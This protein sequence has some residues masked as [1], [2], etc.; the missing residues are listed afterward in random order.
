MTSIQVVENRPESSGSY[1]GTTTIPSFVQDV[2]K[3]DTEFL[4]K[5]EKS[6]IRVMAITS[7]FQ[8]ILEGQLDS[9]K[10]FHQLL[11][12]ISEIYVI[13][14]YSCFCL[15]YALDAETRK[16]WQ[17]YLCDYLEELSMFGRVLNSLYCVFALSHVADKVVLRKNERLKKLDFLTDLLKLKSENNWDGLGETERKDLLTCIRRKV[18][19][20]GVIRRPTIMSI[21]LYDFIAC[22]LFLYRKRPGVI[23]SVFAVC[24]GLLMFVLVDLVISHYFNLYLSYIITTDCLMARIGSL[25]RR[26]RELKSS[27]TEEGLRELLIDVDL[28]KSTF[29]VYSRIMKPLLR[30]LVYIFKGGVALLLF[31][32]TIETSSYM[33]GIMVT[34]VFGMSGCVMV[35]GIY[36][37]QLESQL[38]HLYHELQGLSAF[39]GYLREK[40][41][42]KSRSNLRLVVKELGTHDPGG[43]FIIG[44]TDGSGP[45]ISKK[46]MTD[47][48]LDTI[49]NTIMFMEMFR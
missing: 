10:R 21:N 31:L 8:D 14:K 2:I 28:L 13:I 4:D 3:D 6:L 33:M 5:Y 42:V 1:S 29:D 11:F 17:Y 19:F 45:A 24:H 35:T 9:R 34:T 41:S 37:S 39:I 32:A 40:I 43:N 27:F 23:V 36:I 46:E 26:I 49:S 15:L 48:T 47:L 38:T 12:I 30:N 25:S 22:P 7:P 16:Y 20:V 18:N 44:L